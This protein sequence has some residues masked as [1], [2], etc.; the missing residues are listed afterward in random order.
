VRLSRE[1]GGV[2]GLHRT[3]GKLTLLESFFFLK[4]PP[5]ALDMYFKN[6]HYD[7]GQ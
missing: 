7:V 2:G 1:E 6:C 5:D 4:L 3:L